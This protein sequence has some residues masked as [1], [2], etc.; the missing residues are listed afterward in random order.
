MRNR[1]KKREKLKNVLKM[2]VKNFLDVIS[3]KDGRDDNEKLEPNFVDAIT[4]KI[5]QKCIS[6][7]AAR[8]SMRWIWFLAFMS[9]RHRHIKYMSVSLNQH[10]V[11]FEMALYTYAQ[12]H[13]H[14]QFIIANERNKWRIYCTETKHPKRRTM[15]FYGLSTKRRKKKFFGVTKFSSDGLLCSNAADEEQ[16]THIDLLCVL[17][18]IH[19]IC[20]TKIHEKKIKMKE[21]R[22][23]FDAGLHF[24]M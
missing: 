21:N 14:H 17:F 23:V 5:I 4:W 9:P 19:F 7:F 1:K 20:T 24:L 18:Q 10:L 8:F 3:I 15:Q 11:F 16:R 12:H 22:Y 2:Y 13:H 6:L